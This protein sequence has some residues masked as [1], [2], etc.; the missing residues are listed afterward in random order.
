MYRVIRNRCDSSWM[1]SRSVILDCSQLM[2]K[3]LEYNQP[4][5]ITGGMWVRDVKIGIRPTHGEPT[6][7][8]CSK[9]A[10]EDRKQG[11]KRSTIP[12]PSSN[13]IGYSM[14]RSNLAIPIGAVIFRNIIV[15]QGFVCQST[16]KNRSR[17]AMFNMALLRA[18][19]YVSAL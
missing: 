11:A 7:V 2:I 4:C 12:K 14:Y 19:I 6:C 10:R 17:A 8:D 13:C 3:T 5:A 1:T 16:S 15:G 9:T 18:S